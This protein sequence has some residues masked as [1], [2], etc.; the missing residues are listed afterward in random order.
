MLTEEACR[1]L[2]QSLVISHLDY[3]NT[4]FIGLP[5]CG[6]DKLQQI[7]N[8]AVKLVCGSG[9]LESLSEAMYHIH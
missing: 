8:I 5:D 4:L 9:R 1:I 6:L 7:H 3:G 2:V